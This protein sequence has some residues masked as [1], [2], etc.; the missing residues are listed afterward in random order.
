MDKMV[1]KLTAETIA[2][3]CEATEALHIGQMR[4]KKYKEALDAVACLMQDV[5]QAWA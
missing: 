5:H 1:E 2:T 4:D 3:H